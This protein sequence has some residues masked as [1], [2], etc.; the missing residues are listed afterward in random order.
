MTARV[1]RD[2][3]PYDL[4]AKKGLI[5]VTD[6]NVVHYGAIEAA[7]EEL[8]ERFNIRQIA[9]D[10][11]GATQ[12]SQNLEDAGFTV[13]PFG[14]GF[15]DMSPPS[16]EFMKL[17]LEGRLHHGGNEV[18]AWMVDNIHIRT[19]PV[20]NIKPDIAK[21]TETIDGV[22]ATIMALDRANRN[23]GQHNESVYDSR[24]MLVL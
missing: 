10:R 8:G 20:G 3:V 5:Q 13:V 14:Q 1:N 2:R 15:K 18:L 22:V 21:S 24:G 23:G 7:I 11:W 12:M 16:K 4:W 19:D 17:A 6:G 9:F